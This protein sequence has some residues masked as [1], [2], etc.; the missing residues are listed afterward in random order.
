MEI[1]QARLFYQVH[2]VIY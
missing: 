1:V 2:K